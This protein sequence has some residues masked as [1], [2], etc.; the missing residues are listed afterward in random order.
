MIRRLGVI[1]DLHGEHARLARALEWLTGQRLDGLICTG[2][3]ADGRGC[4]NQSCRLLREAGVVTVSG[5]HDRWLLEDRVRHVADA[6]RLEEVDEVNLAFLQS[7][8]RSRS[9]E[10]VA[11]TLLLCHGVGD[12]DLGKV[13]PGTARSRV[14]RSERLDQVIAEGRFRFMVNGHLHYRVLIDF[15]ELLLLNAGTLKGD[16]SGISVMDFADDVVTAWEVSDGGPVRRACEHPLLEA[17]QRRRFRD[18]AEFDGAWE[19]VTLYRQ[20]M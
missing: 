13:W 11:G 12:D 15:H 17:G 10:T 8:P 18:T 3:V 14:E 5:N 2:D 4:I 6:H 1:G 9:L 7:L 19:P 16:Y 20:P